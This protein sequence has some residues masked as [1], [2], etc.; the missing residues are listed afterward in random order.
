MGAEAT[1][2]LVNDR[3]SG[4]N[5]LRNRLGDSKLEYRNHGGYELLFDDNLGLLNRI[6]EVNELLEPIFNKPVFQRDD[7]SIGKFR[8]NKHRVASIVSNSFEGQLNAGAMMKSLV[9]LANQRGVDYLT[10]AQVD[11]LVTD[12]DP[13]KLVLFNE[14][15]GKAIIQ[16]QRLA[17]CTNAFSNF[18]LPD[19][20]IKPGRGLVLITNEIPQLRFQGV[21]HYRQGYYYFRNVGTRVLFGGGRDLDF[22]GE[23]TREFGTNQKILEHL[24]SELSDLILPDLHYEIDQHWSGIMAFGPDKRPLVGMHTSRI[25][26]AVRLGGMGVALGS[27]VG[28]QLARLIS[29]FRK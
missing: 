25:G 2:Q 23:E 12:S 7:D 3:W 16:C 1:R 18:L 24:K 21:F 15:T 14:H 28:E 11:D 6:G 29:F 8:F 17:I 20:E 22:A 5:L 10:G 27:L 13:I 26:F 4:L 9:T 19:L